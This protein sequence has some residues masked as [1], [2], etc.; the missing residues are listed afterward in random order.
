MNPQK[1][2]SIVR[3]QSFIVKDLKGLGQKNDKATKKEKS[4]EPKADPKMRLQD[5][6]NCNKALNKDEQIMIIDQPIMQEMIE[7]EKIGNGQQ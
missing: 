4:Y 1:N 3:A 2:D 5:W 6:I 7:E